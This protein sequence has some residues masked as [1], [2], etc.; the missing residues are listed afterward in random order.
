MESLP[1]KVFRQYFVRIVNAVQRN[2]LLSARK[3]HGKDLIESGTLEALYS[4]RLSDHEQAR[5]ILSDVEQT[6]STRD[7]DVK[8]FKELC[9]VLS[10]L[11]DGRPLAEQI[12]QTYG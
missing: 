4:S 1:L 3:L 7:D 2:P 11:D 9:G 12:M 10:I 5:Y 6:I 8:A